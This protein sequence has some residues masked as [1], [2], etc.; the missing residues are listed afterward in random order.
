MAGDRRL[1]LLVLMVLGVTACEPKDRRAGQWLRGDVVTTPVTDWSFSNDVDE[2]FVETQTWYLVP[3]SVTTT[4][5]TTDGTLYVPALYRGGGDFPTER[6]WNKNIVRDPE[7]RLKIG[8]NIY[9]RTAYLVTD[10]GE[11]GRVLAAFAAKYDY[12]R[13]L[14][15]NGD[16]ASP[17]IILLRMDP[18]GTPT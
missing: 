16:P 9:P 3:H 6:T 7:V 11:R 18:R 15:K 1:Y 4:V 13:E 12:W 8:D 10:A 2:I 14:L 17:K 5:V